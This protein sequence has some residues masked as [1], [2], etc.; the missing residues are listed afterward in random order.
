MAARVLVVHWNEAEARERV[1]RLERAGFQAAPFFVSS[2]VEHL[3]AALGASPPDAVVIDL[4]RQP[5]HGR[6]FGIHFRS[7]KSLR[8]V[9]LVF[10]AGDAERTAQVRTL[11]PDAVFTTWPRI[12]TAIVRA[13]RNRPENPVV[14]GTFAGY[15]GTPL[16][17][18]LRIGEG[19][20][21]ALLDAP[22]D[23]ERKLEPLPAGVEFRK[24]QAGASVILLFATRAE[25]LEHQLAKVAPEMREGR[26]LWL[27]W[28][29]KT[30]GVPSDL[31]EPA[32]RK[33]GL[34]SGLV[35]Y[36]VCAVDETWSGLAFAVRR[37]K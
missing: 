30:S 18:K 16:P 31:S 26:T 15:S 28:P 6:D 1:E 23:F 27:I 22:P 34:A 8:H 36:K 14:P 32:V 25:T 37:S 7:R 4:T 20:T 12:R 17:K 21:V 11:L 35:D 2:G 19:C 9:P 5:S 10:I 29:K 3:H 13:L 33:M 24:K